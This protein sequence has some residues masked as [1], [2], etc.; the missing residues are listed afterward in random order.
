MADAARQ[1]V[2]RILVNCGHTICTDCLESIVG[3]F[4]ETTS[5]EDQEDACFCCKEC[6]EPI[7]NS[8]MVPT[9]KKDSDVLTVVK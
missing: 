7:M 4:L 2:P 6:N 3:E 5:L 8:Q 9:I 1:N